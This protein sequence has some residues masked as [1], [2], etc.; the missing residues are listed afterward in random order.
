MTEELSPEENKIIEIL[1][2]W[3]DTG[4]DYITTFSFPEIAIEII[5]L[6]GEPSR[7]ILPDAGEIRRA[8]K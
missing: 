5:A 7:T 8:E 3:K 2:A 6:Y 4:K 1:E